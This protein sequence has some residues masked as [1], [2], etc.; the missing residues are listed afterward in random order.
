VLL[1]RIE[2]ETSRQSRGQDQILQ[3]RGT[4]FKT[5]ARSRKRT[6]EAEPR[7]WQAK[8]CLE[9]ALMIASLRGTTPCTPD[10]WCH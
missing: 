9:A 3:G 8:R 10:L 7:W 1:G 6:A 2:A 5:K 4:R